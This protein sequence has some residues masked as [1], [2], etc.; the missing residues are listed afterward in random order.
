M[1]FLNV[2]RE[3]ETQT[4]SIGDATQLQDSGLRWRLLQWISFGCLWA[5]QRSSAQVEPDFCVVF[6]SQK[7]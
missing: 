3:K 5:R 7:I 1:P 4:L 2:M 6:N